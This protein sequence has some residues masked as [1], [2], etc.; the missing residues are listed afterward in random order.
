MKRTINEKINYITLIK[1][2]NKTCKK[3]SHLLD[4]PV[5]FAILFG[6]GAWEEV[7]ISIEYIGLDHTFNTSADAKDL[8]EVITEYGEEKFIDGMVKTIMDDSMKEF[9]KY[10][11]RKY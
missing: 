4:T 11:N 10:L 3:V 2:L 5:N 6:E 8:Y 7:I 9:F 1:V